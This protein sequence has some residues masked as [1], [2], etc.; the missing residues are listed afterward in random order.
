MKKAAIII[1]NWNGK[2]FLKNCLDA[3]FRQNYKN[4]HVYFVDNGSIDGSADYVKQNFPKTTIIQLDKNYGFAKGSNEG[5]KEAL[6]DKDIDYI[7]C[8]NNDTIVSKDWLKELVKTAE[9]NPK[10]GMVSSKAYFLNKKIQNAGLILKK[11]ILS[12]KEGGVSLG[13]GKSDLEFKKLNNEIE[14]FAPGGVAPLYKREMM[15]DLLK[16]NHEFFDED[17]F[18][19]VEDWD[20]G[21]VGRLRGWRCL[22]SPK[23]KLIHLHSKSSGIGSAFKIFHSERNVILTA[24]K[25]LPLGLLIQFI[26]YNVK[27]KINY[28]TDQKKNKQRR[29]TKLS[30]MQ[31]LK[32]VLKAYMSSMILLPKMIIK[33]Y[34]IQTKKKVSDDEIR[35]WFDTYGEELKD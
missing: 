7:V 31:I 24:I 34:N 32:I 12:Y 21:F 6:K 2:K 8:L 23:A 3:V 13:Y 22:L 35:I 19:Y 11:E 26:Y 5:I 27:A 29:R 16:I 20:V 1:V 28:I 33:R 15:L 14:I 30:K 4:F 25:N 9:R 10:I 17:F 18:A